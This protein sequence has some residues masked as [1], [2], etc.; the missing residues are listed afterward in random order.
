VRHKLTTHESRT[1]IAQS[2]P[3]AWFNTTKLELDNMIFEGE[4]VRFT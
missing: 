3:T 2:T 4:L 1:L